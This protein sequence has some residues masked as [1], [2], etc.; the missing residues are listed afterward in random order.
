MKPPA[1]QLAEISPAAITLDRAIVIDWQ[2]G[3]LE[4]FLRIKNIDFSWYFQVIGERTE[5]DFPDDR[6]YVLF[7]ASNDSLERLDEVLPTE[8]PSPGTLR[9]PIWRFRDTF[10]QKRAEDVLSQVLAEVGRA[11]ILLRSTSL[12]DIQDIW[13]ITGHTTISH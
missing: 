5:S 13:L 9:V 2:D 3:P 4:G 10:A 11:E 8:G 12:V 7:Q 6:V 1:Q